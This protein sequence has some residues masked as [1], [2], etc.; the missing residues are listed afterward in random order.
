M[1]SDLEFI[2]FGDPM[3][4]W[5]WGFSP[6]VDRMRQVYEIPMRLVVGGLRPGPRADVLDDRLASSLAHHWEAVEQAS[7]Q[8][9][10]RDFLRRRDGWKYDT[11]IPA[12]AVVTVRAVAPGQEFAFHARLQEAFYAEGTDIT[13]RSSYPLLVSEFDL[14]PDQFMTAFASDDMTKRAWADFAEAQSLGVSG[15]PTILVRDGM[16]YGVITRG[17]VS[18]DKLLPAVSDWL[19][20][21]YSHLD[22]A[23]LFCE[24]GVTC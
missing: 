16:E 12:V 3:C 13:D 2:Y 10:D 4:S 11:E 17:Y 5:C 20:Q 19:L 6:V 1:K 15:F 24:P 7:G 23:A 14:D 22:A 18:E 8:P 9:F 21:R